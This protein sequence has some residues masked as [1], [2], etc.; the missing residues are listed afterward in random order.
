MPLEDASRIHLEDAFVKQLASHQEIS[1]SVERN[2]H[3]RFE[4]KNLKKNCFFNATKL[5]EST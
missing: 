3:L 1:P 5:L 4:K 2:I